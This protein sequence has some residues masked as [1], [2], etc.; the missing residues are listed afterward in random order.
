MDKRVSPGVILRGAVMSDQSKLR[1]R[2]NCGE[3]E[4]G[5]DKGKGA[6]QARKK[7]GDT[8]QRK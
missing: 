7:G 1:K 8:V 2:K 4:R 6:L 3:R 5:R